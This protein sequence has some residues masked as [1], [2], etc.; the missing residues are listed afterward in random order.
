MTKFLLDTLGNH[1]SKTMPF[2]YRQQTG[3]KNKQEL[4][5][6]PNQTIPTIIRSTVLIIDGDHDPR[7]SFLSDP[8]EPSH[9][10]RM[11]WKMSPEYAPVILSFGLVSTDR[12]DGHKNDVRRPSSQLPRHSRQL[13]RLRN[14]RINETAG[15][16]C[17][18]L[19]RY[20][21]LI[22]PAGNYF[23]TGCSM[24]MAHGA[25]SDS[26]YDIHFRGISVI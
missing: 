7:S 25:Q 22:N 6:S 10:V 11:R 15:N 26:A 5:C 1:R 3:W 16:T 9:Q 13:C 20:S 2:F 8:S 12:S 24:R 4:K 21:A 17:S 19:V 23:T 18:F 14:G